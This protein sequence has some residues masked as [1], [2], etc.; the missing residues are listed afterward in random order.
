M[1]EKIELFLLNFYEYI[2]NKNEQ[3][4]KN[5]IYNA[6]MQLRYRDANLETK[7]NRFWKDIV[8]QKTNFNKQ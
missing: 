7:L 5:A 2:K 4:F 6:I 1:D 3:E 8:S